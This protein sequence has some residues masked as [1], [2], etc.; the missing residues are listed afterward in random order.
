MPILVF[1]AP[2]SETAQQNL[3]RFSC[4]DV[5]FSPSGKNSNI[6]RWS[7][8]LTNNQWLKQNNQIP[9]VEDFN[10]LD[11]YLYDSDLLTP[12]SLQVSNKPSNNYS[13]LYI[14]SNSVA[15]SQTV[16]VEP[17]TAYV[18]S[19]VAGSEFNSN[20]QVRIF[21]NSTQSNIVAANVALTTTNT[22]IQQSFVTS[23]SC[24]S[25]DFFLVDYGT[26]PQT[27]FV[28]Q[29]QL[30]TGNV[31]TEFYPTFGSSIFQQ[32]AGSKP[33]RGSLSFFVDNLY[34]WDPIAS[35][36]GSNLFSYSVID[37]YINDDDL[38]MANT[39]ASTSTKILYHNSLVRPY[40]PTR[41]VRLQ[42]L[43]QVLGQ[44]TVV[45]SQ[46]DSITI[47][48]SDNLS[49]TNGITIV[50]TYG[51][52]V[53]ENRLR[54][55]YTNG[56]LKNYN[57]LNRLF[58]EAY[59]PQ[60]LPTRIIFNLYDGIGQPSNFRTPDFAANVKLTQ[61]YRVVTDK[62]QITARHNILGQS[63]LI[64]AT[65]FR[66][67]AINAQIWRNFVGLENRL[68]ER[69]YVPQVRLFFDSFRV[70][71]DFTKIKFLENR[72]EDISRPQQLKTFSRVSSLKI[73]SVAFYRNATLT[74][75]SYKFFGVEPKTTVLSSNIVST[76]QSFTSQ[77]ISNVISTRPLTPT[78]VERL[79]ISNLLN[80]VDPLRNANVVIQSAVTEPILANLSIYSNLMQSPPAKVVGTDIFVNNILD[81]Y[82]YDYD[83]VTYSTST[84]PTQTFSITSEL[85]EPIPAAY[86]DGVNSVVE[87]QA[88][89]YFTI[90]SG[91][92]DMNIMPDQTLNNQVILSVY[93][94]ELLEFINL[95]DL[96]YPTAGIITEYVGDYIVII[97]GVSGTFQ[98]KNN[99]NYK[100]SYDVEVLLVGGGGGGGGSFTGANGGGGGGAIVHMTE[101]PIA[102]DIPYFIKVG[103][104]GAGGNGA[105]GGNGETTEAFGAIAAGGGGGGA[106]PTTNGLGGEV[107]SSGGAGGN[108]IGGIINIS[109]GPNGLISRLA[110]LSTGVIY[111]GTQGGSLT[112]VR[113]GTSTR[114]AGGGGAG[115]PAPNTNPNTAGSAIGYGTEGSGGPGI[116]INILSRVCYFSGGGGGG[117]YQTTAGNGGFGGGGG[118]GAYATSAGIFNGFNG[119]GSYLDT[120]IT[121]IDPVGS[122]RTALSL[123]NAGTALSGGGG[124]GG[125]GG[126]TGVG[127]GSGGSGCAIIKIQYRKNSVQYLPR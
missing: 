63:S 102:P 17:D 103:T 61:D 4:F 2:G 3:D 86:F 35:V 65:L 29:P 96:R 83:I 69:M 20:L 85:E 124:G 122:G 46:N 89:D 84:K 23:S 53:T 127:G 39:V 11:S 10:F 40:L 51:D 94:D 45:A 50:P 28:T 32:F 112:A 81:N 118:G 77:N 9:I 92:F 75:W 26:E 52:L 104:G 14:R 22:R 116:P 121:N 44:Y 12:P 123:G 16:S 79:I 43:T 93:R 64:D 49:F 48:T 19:F 97:F 100:N 71:R 114:G 5:D 58:L 8:N 15:L 41:P 59:Y 117:G 105:A 98:I 70:A 101:V 67:G 60:Q 56:L 82:L 115:G 27:V 109:E 108:N 1:P 36:T 38:F 57:S 106:Y 13:V 54:Y 78:T 68:T 125:G 30:Q 33:S 47:E 111:N 99:L 66:R 95:E 21:C 120:I 72:I 25:V 7:E 55:L 91:A 73:N 87:T 90:M 31:F 34:N 110:P 6:L 126:F 80:F 107:G 88:S 37:S 18:A 113:T 119:Y 62:L 42:N 76:A 24:Y 74:N